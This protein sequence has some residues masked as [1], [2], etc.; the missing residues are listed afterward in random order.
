MFL[1]IPTTLNLN[2]SNIKDLYSRILVNDFVINSFYYL[3]TSFWYIPL[4]L[5]LIITWNFSRLSLFITKEKLF[6]LFMFSILN[7]LLILDYWLLN[8]NYY[9]LNTNSEYFNNLLS[10]SINKYHPGLF[11]FTSLTLFLYM[12]L[13]SILMTLSSKNFVLNW[14]KN[15]ISNKKTNLLALTTLTLFFGGWW[16]LQEG[17]WGGW[18]NWDPSEVFGLLFILLFSWLS[19]QNYLKTSIFILVNNFF[20]WTLP[21]VIIYIFIQ[22]NFDLVSHNFGTKI[23][24]FIDSSQILTVLL[25]INILFL[26]LKLVTTYNRLLS[27]LSLNGIKHKYSKR[28]KFSLIWV[29]SIIFISSLQIFFSFLPLINDFTWKVLHINIGNFSNNWLYYNY[30]ILL[31]LTYFFWFPTSN[32]I[33]YVYELI[34][35]PINIFNNYLTFL[36]TWRLS[37]LMHV[38]LIL[39]FLACIINSTFIYSQW[40]LNLNLIPLNNKDFINYLPEVLS[41]NNGFIETSSTYF[42]NNNLIVSFNFMFNDTTNEVYSFFFSMTN[43]LQNQTLLIGSLIFPYT[44]NTYDFLPQALLSFMLIILLIIIYNP[45]K[46]EL[47]IF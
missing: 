38:F 18:W 6:F 47:I 29:L 20:L 37:F 1:F 32:T 21:I 34:L 42:S 28:F 31:L 14:L 43:F 4:L 2:Y 25:L 26:N 13:Y 15:S 19:H 44:I 17:S 3:W 11:Y 41:I 9:T 35:Q 12:G 27:I 10:N 8:I 24:Q 16:A 22:L 45:K 5:L 40:S 39:F 7:Y 23:D 30:T 46:L 33:F 36:H